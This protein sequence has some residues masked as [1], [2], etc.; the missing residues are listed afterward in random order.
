M[1]VRLEPLPPNTRLAFGTRVVFADEPLTVR[2]A[3]AVSTSPTVKLSGPVEA[4]WLMDWLVTSEMV[5]ASFTELT[6]SRNAALAVSEPSL[7]V[8]VMVLVP[9]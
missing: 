2:L 5:G 4:S 8:T 9:N 7:T 1:T 6:V 3:A